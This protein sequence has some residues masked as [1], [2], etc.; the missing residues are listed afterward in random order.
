EKHIIFLPANAGKIREVMT[1]EIMPYLEN[2]SYVPTFAKTVK[3]SGIEKKQVA[4]A[5]ENIN[6]EG[7]DIALSS[8][9]GETDVRMT[10]KAADRNKA[11]LAMIPVIEGLKKCFGSHVFTDNENIALEDSVIASL[12]DRRMTI[13]T[14]E[15]CT[16]GLLAGRLVNVSGASEVFEQ[17]FIT[18]SDYAKNHLINVP[19]D[20]LD[21][22]GAVSEQT[23]K[24]MAVNVA[25]VSGARVG[26]GITGIAGPLG[27]TP[28]KPV[29]LVYISCSINGEAKVNRYVF[30]G[31]RQMIREQSVMYALDMIRTMVNDY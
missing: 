10:A 16:G 30:K 11:Y 7:I 13:A 19:Q 12:R 6:A 31:S 23:A 27:G 29:G 22:Y 8:Y 26:V 25:E 14:A 9:I 20:I 21:K 28:E 1:K 5:L 15:S 17:G 4:D 3:I 2:L 18:Y 24:A